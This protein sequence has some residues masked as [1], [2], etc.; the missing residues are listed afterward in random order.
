MEDYLEMVYRLEQEKGYVKVID[1]AEA[2][3]VN[4]SSV[5]R[6]IQKLDEAGFLSYVKYRNIALNERGRKIGRFLVWRD[7]MLADF[8][9]LLK[10]PGGVDDQVEGIEHYITPHTMS[11]IR[12]LVE[13]FSSNPQRLKELEEIQQQPRYPDGEEL[14]HLRCWLFQ[15]NR[16]D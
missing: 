7:Q 3:H 16:E 12:N 4:S 11:L 6:M 5:T 15:H 9:N 1:L 10:A 13:Y 2:L 14:P 8:L